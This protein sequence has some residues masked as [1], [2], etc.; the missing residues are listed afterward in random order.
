[1]Q[2]H[3]CADCAQLIALRFS[4]VA[5]NFNVNLQAPCLVNAVLS[6]MVAELVPNRPAAC[7]NLGRQLYPHLGIQGI[8]LHS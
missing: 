5:A 1:M 8:L 6:Y 4:V 3:P 7:F 2:G